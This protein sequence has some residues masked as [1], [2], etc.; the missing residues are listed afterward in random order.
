MKISIDEKGLVH[1]EKEKLVED[2]EIKVFIRSAI[3][4]L[5]KSV[6]TLE[7]LYEIQRMFRC[8][9]PLASLTY[10]LTLLVKEKKIIIDATGGGW[11]YALVPENNL[12]LHI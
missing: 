11:L 6:T 1:W 8:S 12:D 10:N 4:S 2:N 9:I 3:R 5:G 7:I